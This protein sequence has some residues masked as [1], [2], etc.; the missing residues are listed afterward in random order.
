[1]FEGLEWHAD[2]LCREIGGDVFFPEV[3]DVTGEIVEPRVLVYAAKRICARC[4]V[5][6]QC[7]EYALDNE[8]VHG[9]WGG[10]SAKERQRMFA[11][12]RRRSRA[13]A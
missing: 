3:I 11:A 1:M 13:G 6:V 8:E 5:R 4:P 10:T 9:V 7:L 12:A 2:A